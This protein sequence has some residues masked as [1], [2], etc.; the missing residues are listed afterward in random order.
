MSDQ[1]VTTVWLNIR[2]LEST[3]GTQSKQ[4]AFPT[5]T[6][7][8]IQ[9][10]NQPTNQPKWNSHYTAKIVETSH[11]AAFI[12]TDETP[13]ATYFRL[14]TLRTWPPTYE[15]C[16]V[17]QRPLCGGEHQDVTDEV[18]VDSDNFVWKISRGL[19]SIGRSRI[20]FQRLLLFSFDGLLQQL[21]LNII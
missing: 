19:I 11:V 3:L 10:T 8:F 1:H 13:Q 7:N 6:L 4:C 20:H 14:C 12:E 5:P 9:P 16:K 17:L 21:E 2:A 18:T 15:Q